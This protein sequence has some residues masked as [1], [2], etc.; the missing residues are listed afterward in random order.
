MK[1]YTYNEA[2]QELNLSEWLLQGDYAGRIYFERRGIPDFDDS[3][4]NKCELEL[5][6]CRMF[7]EF[8]TASSASAVIPYLQLKLVDINKTKSSL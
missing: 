6:G 7:L 1:K 2:T 8:E 3:F 4:C 5:N